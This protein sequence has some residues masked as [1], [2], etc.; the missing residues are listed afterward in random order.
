M[1]KLKEKQIKIIK[2]KCETNLKPK[3]MV[4]I[5]TKQLFIIKC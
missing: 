3:F 4:K 5:E 2:M 1:K